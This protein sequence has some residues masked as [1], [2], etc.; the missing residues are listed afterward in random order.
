[1]TI[2]EMLE[3][4]EEMILSPYASLA[5]KS[6][7]RDVPETECDIRTVY[8]RD[9]DRIVHCKAFRRLKDKT[10]VFLIPEGDHYRT[11]LTHTLE[12]SQIARTISKALR[13]NED[14][15]EA[16]ALGHDLGHTPF[17]HAGE[18]ALNSVCPFRFKH[19]EQS[20]RTVEKLERDGNGLNLTWEVRNGILNHQISCTPATLEGKVVRL[21]DKIAYIHHDMDDAVRAGVLTEMD[22]PAEIRAVLGSTPGDRLDAFLHDIITSSSD[23]N[24][25]CMTDSVW[26]AMRDIRTFM[27]ERV[28]TNPDI[29]A[30]EGKAEELVCTLY[31]YYL[32]H[33]DKLPVENRKMA[34]EG[35]PLERCVCDFVG[36]MTDRFAILTYNELFV[37]KS[38]EMI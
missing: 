34:D 37:P 6:K 24:D 17:G 16:I 5:K 29:K 27:F 23:R 28:Y 35:E 22:V 18:R 13:L 9:R 11:R 19:N 32:H 31:D 1:M 36:A 21:S 7:G 14:L 3:E 8:Q 15:T 10:Q 33:P 4:R 25:I 12:V 20:V 26:K 2:R 38:W 30:E